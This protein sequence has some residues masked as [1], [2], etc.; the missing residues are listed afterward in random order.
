MK[1]NNEEIKNNDTLLISEIQN[2]VILPYTS[3]EIKKII[4]DENNN[5]KTE[6]EVIN[7]VYTKPISD[8][9]FQFWSRY[10]ETIKL[11]LERENYMLI[12]AIPLALE[13]LSKKY[14]YPAIITAC[15]NLSELNVY[16]DCLD[17]NELDDFKIFNIKYEIYPTVIK[18][19]SK[20]YVK[21][22]ILS[23][24]MNFFKNILKTKENNTREY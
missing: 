11:M 24:I 19:D 5:Y 9:K 6:E 16:I 15:R 4:E 12:D 22:S 10:K 17:K 13:M 20:I 23:R 18:N 1:N 2:K 3:E 21:T 14:L 8:Y 7:N